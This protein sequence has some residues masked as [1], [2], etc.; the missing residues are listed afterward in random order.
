MNPPIGEI[1]DG[2]SWSRDPSP[3]ED[4]QIDHLVDTGQ[5]SE[6]SAR[7]MVQGPPSL[8]NS[9]QPARKPKRRRTGSVRD[10]ADGGRAD[11][12]RGG[13]SGP[14]ID[15]KDRQGIAN[16]RAELQRARLSHPSSVKAEAVREALNEIGL[17]NTAHAA[18]GIFAGDDVSDPRR[19]HLGRYR[20]GDHAY[21]LELR[22]KQAAKEA[23]ARACGA[24]AITDCILRDN[25]S[26]FIRVYSDTPTR[27][28]LRTAMKKSSKNGTDFDCAEPMKKK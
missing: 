15:D 5:F 1:P 24:C 18:Y 22:H 6:D 21:D 11:E 28:R 14:P 17:A 13:P 3:E 27:N 26:L 9:P 23:S 20:D 12:F 16:I 25:T 2:N 4:A 7:R 19:E 10:F 8:E